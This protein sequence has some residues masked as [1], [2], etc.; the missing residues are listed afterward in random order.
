MIARAFLL[1][2]FLICLGP[3]AP[4][5]Q[6]PAGPEVEAQL[7]EAAAAGNAGRYADA[8]AI[9]RPLADA[10][11]PRA[12]YNM[13][14]FYA[15]GFGVPVSKETALAWFL[16][17][18]A[19]GEANG[20]YHVALYHDQG[21]GTPQAPAVALDYYKRAGDAGH[22]QAAYNA[23]QLLL[24]G[25]G[26]Q[27]NE[28]E[29]A[30]YLM[31]AAD[32][33]EASARALLG[34]GWIHEKGI[35]VTPN[36][37]TASHYYAKAYEAGLPYARDFIYGLYRAS[38]ERAAA[39]FEA[40]DP[41]T[42]MTVLDELCSLTVFKACYHAGTYR[43]RGTYGV[44]R[45]AQKAMEDLRLP[46][47]HKLDGACTYLAEAVI[48]APGPFRADDVKLAADRYR[49]GCEAGDQAL[50]YNLAYMKYYSRFDMD[51]YEGAKK[52]LA[53]ACFHNGYQK[54]CGPF[55]D[56]F[57]A[58]GRA[59]GWIGEPTEKKKSIWSAID[60][61]LAPLA[62]AMV[63]YSQIVSSGGY[64]TSYGDYTP[65]T[66][67]YNQVSQSNAYRDNLQFNEMISRIET[68]GTATNCSSG[69]PYC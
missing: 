30:Q 26:V 18:A 53:Q 7:D 46:C 6:L 69:N 5:Q 45:D 13:G 36:I 37:S 54:A 52:L 67:S 61:A 17:A 1:S 38:S 39:A 15:N 68:Y 42:G 14:L 41:V 47:T 11:H 21:L 32:A 23:A 56:M 60:N 51:D 66:S 34:A 25:D 27:A 59:M 64:S 2:L 44:T 28:T 22:A 24:T 31:M 19:Q 10:G 35:G 48:F 65:P 16:K 62:D 29:G 63:G 43:L 12:Q 55:T 9:Y 3:A 4:A 33:E 50:C 8:M 40:G 58:E 20:L 57:N 49:Q